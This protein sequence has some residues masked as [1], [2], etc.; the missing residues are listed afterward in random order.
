MFHVEHSSPGSTSP[1]APPFRRATIRR[2]AGSCGVDPASVGWTAGAEVCGVMP[3]GGPLACRRES[4][5][6]DGANKLGRSPPCIRYCGSSCQNDRRAQSTD[7]TGSETTFLLLTFDPHPPRVVRPR[8]SVVRVVRPS[9]VL[10][11]S[12]LARRTRA[13]CAKVGSR[14]RG[15]MGSESATACAASH[16]A[17]PEE[18]G[19]G[20]G[21]G[22]HHGDNRR[23]HRPVS[24]PGR[25]SK[26]GGTAAVPVSGVPSCTRHENAPGWICGGLGRRHVARA[27]ARRATRIKFAGT[28]EREVSS[29]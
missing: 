7:A 29:F 4:T 8:P 11:C 28:R 6:R 10:S 20:T 13:R 14:V 3:I 9:V 25:Y 24:I 12:A 15:P 22:E 1:G 19:E 16:F 18:S 23:A 21:T 26:I 5:A 27:V 2:R 17:L